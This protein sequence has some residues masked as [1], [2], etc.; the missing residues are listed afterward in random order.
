VVLMGD[1]RAGLSPQALRNRGM[2]AADTKFG[3]GG[4]HASFFSDVEGVL[5]KMKAFAHQ[6]FNRPDLM[7]AKKIEDAMAKGLDYFGFFSE[8]DEPRLGG[9]HL[10]QD[11]FGLPSAA[12]R[13]RKRFGKW[14]P[15]CG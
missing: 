12:L 9:L 8:E 6:E 2:T 4:W 1:I 13:D 11:C 5:A 14:L 15:D 3:G 10:N 7:D